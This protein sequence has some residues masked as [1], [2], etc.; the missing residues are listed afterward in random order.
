MRLIERKLFAPVPAYALRVFRAA[1]GAA[2][3]VKGIDLAARLRD[4][5][6]F[7]SD[8][9][10]WLGTLPQSAWPIVLA[11]WFV[12]AGALALGWRGRIAAA[13]LALV[14]AFVMAFAG[15]YSNHL[16]LLA[17]FAALLALVDT[18]ADT[19][20]AWQLWLLQLQVSVVYVFSALAKLNADFLPGNVL[21]YRASSSMFLP[22]LEPVAVAPLFAGLSVVAILSELVIAGA[23][24]SE[25][26]RALAF[27]LGGLLHTGMLV[28]I[29]STPELALRLVVFEMLML[30][31][32][33]LFV[34]PAPL[35]RTVVW[36][37][38]C[39]FCR[40]WVTWF[41]R[42]D[43]LHALRFVGRSDLE[44]NGTSAVLARH[45]LEAVQLVGPH[46]TRR[47]GFEAVR[48]VAAV[49]PATFLVAPFMGIG[50]V[51]VVGDRAYRA[52][53]A[54]RTCRLRAPVARPSGRFARG[55]PEELPAPDRELA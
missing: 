7:R 10:D 43:W 17:T 37:D 38:G 53:A 23:L 39:G 14:A 45:A 30:S 25:R 47:G 36:D 46:G 4:V 49:L 28:A 18:R 54:R 26:L 52:V 41:G 33:L 11:A 29:S 19:V 5:G 9:L 16:Y 24:W 44:R 13:G 21:Y 55:A 32:Y 20:P 51:R 35:A 48:R 12:A 15:M 6:S 31:S 50:P 27:G 2:A 22:D 1:V 42:L 3:L 40:T 34:A 8:S